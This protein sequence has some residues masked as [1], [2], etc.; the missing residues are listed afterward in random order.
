MLSVT[1]LSQV[2]PIP[3]VYSIYSWS[4]QTYLC[5]DSCSTYKPWEGSDAVCLIYH[6]VLVP[7]T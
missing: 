3:S 7:G 6:S 1:C 2:L 4:L 5:V